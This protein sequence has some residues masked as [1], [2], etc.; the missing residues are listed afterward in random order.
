MINKKSIITYTPLIVFLIIL[1]I[2]HSSLNLFSDDL[3]FQSYYKVLFTLDSSNFLFFRFTHWSWRIL[4]EG[5]LTFLCNYPVL[6]IIGD[7]ILIALLAYLVPKL[8]IKNYDEMSN[9]DK[10]KC[11]L[12]GILLTILFVYSNIQALKSAG[13]IATTLNYTWP[14]ILGVLHIY[15]FK[16]YF[17]QKREIKTP[18]KILIGII[19][20]LSLIFAINS[21][22]ILISIALFY[23]IFILYKCFKGNENFLNNLLELLKSNKMLLLYLLIILVMFIIFI[24]CPGNK[25]RYMEE[26]GRWGD[27]SVLK[28]YNKIDLSV[29]TLYCVLLTTKDLLACLFFI[30]L[31]IYS[32]KF[33]NNKLIKFIIFIPA[34]FLTILYLI[35]YVNVDINTLIFNHVIKNFEPY[36][37][38]SHGIS[39]TVIT[40]SVSYLIIIL[41]VLIALIV[42][43]KHN[44]KIS[45]IIFSLLII[46]FISQFVLG[47]S[48]SCL[49]WTYPESDYPGRWWIIS[50][51]I[52]I[53]TTG[54]LIFELMKN[55]YCMK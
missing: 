40:L 17:Y 28:F 25:V 34:I 3:Y 18:K 32:S 51:G 16:E 52:L 31:A 43:Y 39:L 49:I 15:L 37:L 5:V 8:I 27:Y 19:S 10:I 1:L 35:T 54:I 29:T 24:K 9:K 42:T 22:I 20:V 46:A 14:F 6:W 30:V 33:T 53:F 12:I 55:K 13:F 44:Q 48:P 38:F 21:E 47:F 11:S 36:G 50:N 2:I 4:I 41:S 45:I 26:I 23:L 7:S